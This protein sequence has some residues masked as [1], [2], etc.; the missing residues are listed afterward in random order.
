MDPHGD[1]AV[2]YAPL[3]GAYWLQPPE[4]AVPDGVVDRGRGWSRAVMVICS[5]VTVATAVVLAVASQLA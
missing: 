4:R 3:L 2:P 1:D 5:V